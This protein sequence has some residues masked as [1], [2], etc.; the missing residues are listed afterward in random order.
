MLDRRQHLA[1][2]E[3]DVLFGQIG[4]HGAEHEH[5]QQFR[6]AHAVVALGYGL[7]HRVRAA[8]DDDATLDQ[9]LDGHAAPVLRLHGQNLIERLRAHVARR[10]EHELARLGQ[11]HIEHELDMGPSLV[12][13]LLVGL[14]H[15]DGGAPG[16]LAGRGL[17]AIL[18]PGGLAIHVQ[19]FRHGLGGAVGL[20]IDIFA[21]GMRRPFDGLAAALGGAPDRR[22]GLLEGAR[23]EI[24]IFEMIVLALIGEG[25]GFRPGAHH[26][27]RRLL[28]TLQRVDGIGAEGKILRPHP[29]HKAADEPP[30]GDDVDHGVFFGQGQRILAQ[31]EGV[32][33]NGDAPL[34]APRQG[35]GHDHG[36]GHQPICALVMLIDAHAV[37]AQFVGQLQL[38]KIAIVELMAHERVEMIVGQHHPGA[39]IFLANARVDV[40]VGH[41]VK[42]HDLHGVSFHL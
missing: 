28:V 19:I 4:G 30:A 2:E 6:E 26:E 34:G 39:A 7:A 42:T 36:R 16:D 23:P 35:R 10:E 27:V 22:M 14:R 29:A 33:Q 5:A 21:V 9:R 12:D 37:K 20:E 32:A 40:G 3:A 38:V 13:G 11:Q 15:I 41:K 18:A 31:A 8:A 25:P 17:V 1:G 24:H